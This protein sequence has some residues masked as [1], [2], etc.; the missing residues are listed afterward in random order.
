MGLQLKSGLE[1]R[2]G[3]DPAACPL[4]ARLSLKNGPFE[5]EIWGLLALFCFA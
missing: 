5:A 3:A 4:K 1:G 2:I